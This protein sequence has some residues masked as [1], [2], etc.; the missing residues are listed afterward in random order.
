MFTSRTLQ[1]ELMLL[2]SSPTPRSRWTETQCRE[3]INDH[4]QLN[5]GIVPSSPF[6]GSRRPYVVKDALRFHSLFKGPLS[7]RPCA[8]EAGFSFRADYDK[9]ARYGSSESLVSKCPSLHVGAYQGYSLVQSALSERLL[10]P[11]RCGQRRKA[12]HQSVWGFAVIEMETV[13]CEQALGRS[14]D[15]FDT[16]K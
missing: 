14:M 7:I 13:F 16:L 5:E 9:M 11:V 1:A 6:I 3:S 8:V 12:L 10:S 4:C 15:Y 2:Y